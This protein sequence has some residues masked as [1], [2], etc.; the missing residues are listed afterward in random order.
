MNRPLHVVLTLLAAAAQGCYRERERFDV[1]V[2]GLETADTVIAPGDTIRAAARAADGT[3]LSLLRVLAIAARD[4]AGQQMDTLHQ[5]FN[6]EDEREVE[7]LLSIP[8]EATTP[9]GTFIEIIARAIDTQDFEVVA[10]DTVF[11]RERP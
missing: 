4:V 8:V 9:P 7:I 3:G 11:V 6:L 5:R 10:H 1:P 2:L